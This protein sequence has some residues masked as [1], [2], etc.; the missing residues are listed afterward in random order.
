MLAEIGQNVGK[1]IRN[2][3]VNPHESCYTDREYD[4]TAVMGCCCGLAGGDA[5]THYLQYDCIGCPHLTV[6][7]DVTEGEDE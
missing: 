6:P 3:L 1:A 5:S 7:D 2:I 4:G